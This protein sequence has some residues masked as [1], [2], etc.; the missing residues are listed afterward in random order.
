MVSLTGNGHRNP[1]TAG[2]THKNSQFAR[3][4]TVLS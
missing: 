4:A 2:Q 3:P 1:E